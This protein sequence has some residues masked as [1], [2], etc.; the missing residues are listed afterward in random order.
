MKGQALAGAGWLLPVLASAFLYRILSSIIFN[1]SVKQESCPVHCP[2]NYI[3]KYI[4]ENN[5]ATD[6]IGKKKHLVFIICF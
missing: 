1:N 3:M 2:Y 6:I 5:H 4:H